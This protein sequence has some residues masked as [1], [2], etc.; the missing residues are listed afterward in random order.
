M[1]IFLLFLFILFQEACSEEPIKGFDFSSELSVHCPCNNEKLGENWI[2]I[3]GIEPAP[4]GLPEI[5]DV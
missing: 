1:K 3:A 4:E 5:D 2:D